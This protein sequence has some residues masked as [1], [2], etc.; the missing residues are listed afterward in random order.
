M[1]SKLHS[2]GKTRKLTSPGNAEL[3]KIVAKYPS[4]A[5]VL[6]NEQK[7]IML[8]NLLHGTKLLAIEEEV[9]T[10]LEAVI[11]QLDSLR[12]MEEI[13]GRR[14]SSE[15]LEQGT[16]A[17][18]MAEHP[19]LNTYMMQFLGDA[20]GYDELLRQL[21]T[22]HNFESLEPG[23][24]NDMIYQVEQLR[25]TF[26]DLAAINGNQHRPRPGNGGNGSGK[27]AA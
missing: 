21:I 25:T 27:Q 20:V 1:M 7:A 5:K 6:E 14:P 18:L 23:D 16:A 9:S 3:G 24:I 12:K 2:S 4:I 26:R 15:V 13:V 8:N 19:S 11:N 10:K 17:R 22:H